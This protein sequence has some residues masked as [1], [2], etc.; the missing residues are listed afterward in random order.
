MDQLANELLNEIVSYLDGP[1]FL[2]VSFVSRRL[3]VI[4]EPFLY[5]VVHLTYDRSIPS[6]FQLFCRTILARSNLARYVE[7]LVLRWIEEEVA[8]IRTTG[9]DMVPFTYEQFIAHDPQIYSATT[10]EN[11]ELEWRDDEY[12][13]NS[14]S[15]VLL[16]L[17]ILPS[18]QR[19][20]VLAPREPFKAITNLFSDRYDLPHG[21]RPMS[22][23]SLRELR[24]KC[25]DRYHPVFSCSLSMLA[26]SQLRSL[27]K[28]DIS[29]VD[30]TE[31]ES[32]NNV[33]FRG[34][35]PITH[36]S[37]R[38]SSS[39]APLLATIMA[40]PRALT[41]L[42][43][44]YT[45]GNNSPFQGPLFGTT[46]QPLRNTLQE[47]NIYL[48]NEPKIRLWGDSDYTVGSLRDWT[49]LRHVR[50]P[51]RVLEGHGELANQLPKGI[52][53]FVAE[54]DDFDSPA[55]V[56]DEV[57]GLVARK[58]E[59]GLDLFREVT[60]IGVADGHIHLLQAVCVEAG[61]ELVPGVARW[62]SYGRVIDDE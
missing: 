4:A 32:L 19:L 13:F 15:D 33:S 56:V 62:D 39:S 59:C 40:H 44:V 28:L 23:H 53:R 34:K 61:V 60:V 49:V 6:T 43:L 41:H 38:P 17:S 35:S 29:H 31:P 48:V 10:S 50:C 14:V 58:K 9:W 1:S 52:V 20:D 18:L 46:L 36:L 24:L 26:I 11:I 45:I 8:D 55:Y 3:H 30:M 54:E 5:R 7:V 12:L 37:I 27:R 42:E 2:S 21:N 25:S 51:V 57:I 22:F 47:L 16:L